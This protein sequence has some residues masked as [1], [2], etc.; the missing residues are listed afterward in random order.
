MA[1]LYDSTAAIS[2]RNMPLIAVIAVF[3]R[4]ATFASMGRLLLIVRWLNAASSAKHL[5]CK[6]RAKAHFSFRRAMA[7][8]KRAE[9]RSWEH[10]FPVLA[11]RLQRRQ[12]NLAAICCLSLK[13]C[14]HAF[15]RSRFGTVAFADGNSSSIPYPVQFARAA[16]LD[17][18]RSRRLAHVA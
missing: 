12:C 3:W 6:F 8:A 13:G 1:W 18:R 5:R 2:P 17:R 16:N 10:V 14:T 7:P 11:H 9:A 4:E 15:E